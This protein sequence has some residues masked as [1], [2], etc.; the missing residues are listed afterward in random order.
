ME[1]AVAVVILIL[2]FILALL[3]AFTLLFAMGAAAFLRFGFCLGPRRNLRFCR[4]L[5]G[6]T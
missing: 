2:I 5:L 4:R 3:F 1:K 6:S